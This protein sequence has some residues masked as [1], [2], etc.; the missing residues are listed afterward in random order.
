MLL[1]NNVDGFIVVKS[2]QN[3]G[4]YMNFKVPVIA[5]DRMAFGTVRRKRDC[6]IL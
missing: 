6:Q 1:N 5:I 4:N 2:P 3:G